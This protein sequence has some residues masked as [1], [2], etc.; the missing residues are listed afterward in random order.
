MDVVNNTSIETDMSVDNKGDGEDTVHYGVGGTRGDGGTDGERYQTR[1]KKSL[2]CP[3]VRAVSLVRSREGGGVVDSTAED[4]TSRNVLE[5]TC[6]VGSH[7]RIPLHLAR[8]ESQRSRVVQA[9]SPE[10]QSHGAKSRG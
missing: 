4:G 5:A 1:R 3:V 10:T 9:P 8:S 2:K 6:F 7:Q